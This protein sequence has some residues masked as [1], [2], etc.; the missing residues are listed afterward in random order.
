MST[1]LAPLRTIT[2][3]RVRRHQYKSLG[4]Y[5]TEDRGYVT[6][7]VHHTYRTFDV[8]LECRHTI[9]DVPFGRRPKVGRR[10]R[11]ERCFE[12]AAALE[13]SD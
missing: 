2:N 11:C 3:T 1:D 13:E 8:F 7:T 6:R 10:M 4:Y 9:C 5:R 12:F